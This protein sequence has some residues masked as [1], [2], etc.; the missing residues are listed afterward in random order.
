MNNYQHAHNLGWNW[1][2]FREFLVILRCVGRR[3]RPHRLTDAHME[4]DEWD[5]MLVHGP[6]LQH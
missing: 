5:K 6:G 3:Q 1:G 4:S 2:T